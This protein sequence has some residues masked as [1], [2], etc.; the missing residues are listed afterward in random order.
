MTENQIPRDKVTLAISTVC[1]NCDN[2]N[3]LLSK[4]G[5]TR[6]FTGITVFVNKNTGQVLKKVVNCH[7]VRH[8]IDYLSGDPYLI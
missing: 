8:Q 5:K 6:S 7:Q 2:T 4:L 3:C 1:K